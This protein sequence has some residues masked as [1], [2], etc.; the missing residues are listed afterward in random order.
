MGCEGTEGAEALLTAYPTTETLNPADLVG[1]R[2]ALAE[3]GEICLP[4]LDGSLG[5]RDAWL[6]VE[7]FD[8]L[9]GQ[10]QFIV[11]GDFTE[12]DADGEEVWSGTRSVTLEGRAWVQ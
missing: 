2:I 6:L 3:S 8:V 12:Y 9:A 10:V 4:G 1:E 5:P 7:A 11:K